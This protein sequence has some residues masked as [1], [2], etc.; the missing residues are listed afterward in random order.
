MIQHIDSEFGRIMTKVKDLSLEKY[1]YLIFT[2]DNGPWLKFKHHGGSSGP[3]R[4]G[5]NSTFEGGHRVPFI[6]WG[7]GRIPAN[8]SSDEVVS[9][10][11]LLPSI[12][13]LTGSI[14]SKKNKIDGLDVSNLLTGKS[15]KS[16]RS[17]FLYYTPH[18]F[19]AGMRQGKWKVLKNPKAKGKFMLF[20]LSLDIGESTDLAADHPEIVQAL[21]KRINELDSE[22]TKNARP[23]WDK[24]K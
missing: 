17:E 24:K 20:D 21:F 3:L 2:S 13:S 7:P 4:A 9:T 15:D 18:G 23:V 10:I 6:I 12:A 11:D 5:K 16:P 8:T 1:T 22:I 19:T 14:L